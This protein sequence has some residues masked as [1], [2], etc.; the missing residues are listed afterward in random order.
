MLIKLAVFLFLMIYNSF[1]RNNGK[2][3]KMPIKVSIYGKFMQKNVVNFF[4]FFF[5]TSYGHPLLL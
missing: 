3:V 1:N 5:N 4:L 2:T